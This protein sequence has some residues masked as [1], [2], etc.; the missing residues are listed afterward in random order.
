MDLLLL[1]RKV[2]IL[3]DHLLEIS[4]ILGYVIC[5][6]SFLCTVLLPLSGVQPPTFFRATN[7]RSRYFQVTTGGWGRRRCLL[8][9]GASEVSS[10][11]HSILCPSL[12]TVFNT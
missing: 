2:L 4:S 9:I 5:I 8:T 10:P 7:A 11:H 12:Q 3:S 1:A 6:M